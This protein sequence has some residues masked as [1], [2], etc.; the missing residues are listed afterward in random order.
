[1]GADLT[2]ETSGNPEALDQAIEV[3]GYNGR[4]IIGSWY[5]QKRATLQLGAA[6]HRS[7][8]R[9][10][11]SQ[12]STIQPDLR[13]RWSKERVRQLAWQMLK[14]MQPSRFVTHHFPLSDASE[15]YRLLDLNAGETLQVILTY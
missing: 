3:T 12:V 1:M 13:G 15:A 8:M 14:G 11:S 2:F 10:I 7:R 4:I 9:L 5:G 6:F